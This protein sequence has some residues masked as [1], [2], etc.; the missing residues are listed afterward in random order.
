MLSDAAVA[1]IW[2]A[3]NVQ[4]SAE[5][6]KTNSSHQNNMKTE[7]T[8]STSLRGAA[9]ARTLVLEIFLLLSIR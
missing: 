2:A 7:T 6:K 5:T 4:V 3:I 8:D 1:R 9:L